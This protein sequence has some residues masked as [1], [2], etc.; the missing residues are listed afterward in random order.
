MGTVYEDRPEKDTPPR[1]R[2]LLAGRERVAAVV[3]APPQGLFMQRV[4]YR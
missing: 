1:V 2:A 3:T 4:L